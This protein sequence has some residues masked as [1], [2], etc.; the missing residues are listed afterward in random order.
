MAAA[1][2]SASTRAQAAPTPTPKAA[3]KKEQTPAE[4]FAHVLDEYNEIDATYDKKLSELVPLSKVV[5]KQIAD[6]KAGSSKGP[7]DASKACK[8]LGEMDD[9]HSSNFDYFDLLERMVDDG[10]IKGNIDLEFRW[11]I[12][13]D[14]YNDGE[15]MIK[16]TDKSWG[17]G[18]TKD[19]VKG[20]PGALV[21]PAPTAAE[22]RKQLTYDQAEFDRA[23]GVYNAKLNDAIKVATEP[24]STVISQCAA[25]DRFVAASDDLG[26]VFARLDVMLSSGRTAKVGTAAEVEA[27]RKVFAWKKEGFDVNRI[28]A[29]K[30]RTERKCSTIPSG[31]AETEELDK[32]FSDF[33]IKMPELKAGLASKD[34]SDTQTKANCRVYNETGGLLK[35]MNDAIESM[36]AKGSSLTATYAAKYAS[37]KQ[38][39]SPMLPPRLCYVI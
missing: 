24:G 19:S 29:E 39:R 15:A 12:V 23:Y 37:R 10:D 5:E 33:D 8:V 27:I 14:D 30:D 31:A 17:C 6:I 26:A 1:T 22:D 18:I 25:V 9:I 16:R 20:Q 36:K 34:D 11:G 38:E 35:K 21:I 13:E 32:L 7:L 2:P 3:P 4:L 28:N